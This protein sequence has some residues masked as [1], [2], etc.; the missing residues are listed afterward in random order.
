M[1]L[2]KSTEHNSYEGEAVGASLA[3]WLTERQIGTAN[4]DVSIYV[5]NR[6]VLQNMSELKATSGQHLIHNAIM[7]VNSVRA[8]VKLTW[9]SGHSG[10]PGNEKA[11]KLAKQAASGSMNNKEGSPPRLGR[12]YQ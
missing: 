12:A 8:R 2:G 9:I 10:V 7:V 6:S 1:K 5:D 11:D 4:K 3:A